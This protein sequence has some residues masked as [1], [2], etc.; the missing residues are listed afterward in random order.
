[1]FPQIPE[2]LTALGLTELKA[3]KVEVA[4]A[5][6]AA[7]AAAD[8]SDEDRATAREL[9]ATVVPAIKQAIADAEVAASLADDTTEPEE[10]EV[11]TEPEAAAAAPVAETT[12]EPVAA[13]TPVVT[14]VGAPTAAAA[15]AGRG[16][17]AGTLIAT[18]AAPGM[19]AGEQF[20]DWLTLGQSLQE[21]AKAIRGNSD[22]KHTV[23]TIRGQFPEARQLGDNPTFNLAKFDDEITAAMCAPLPPVYDLACWNT[24]RRPVYNSLPQFQTPTRGGFSIYPSPTLEDITTGYGQWTSVDDANINAVKEACQTIEC[25]TPEEY[26]IYGVYRCLTV[27]NLLQMTYP[28]LVEAYLNR[29][30]AATARLAE[31]LLLEAMA[32]GCTQINAYQLGYNATTSILSTIINYLLLYQESQRWDV[33]GLMEAWAPRWVV[34]AIQM[35]VVRRKRHDGVVTMVPSQATIEGWFREAGINIHWFIDRPS[36]ATAIPQVATSGLLNFAPRNVE[37]LVAPPGKFALMDRGELS[38]G[39]TGN[40]IYRDNTSNS[41][42]EFTM[43]FE[44]FEGVIDTNTCPA[45]IISIDNLCYNGQQIADLVINC[46]GGDEVGAAS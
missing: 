15:S 40:N 2:N 3:L 45:H 14:T 12:P 36:W 13:A 11:V 6:Q 35:D 18:D 34:K 26:R 27:K 17:S 19:S 30:A 41:R 4:R 23:A 43:F 38:I 42:N 24:T 20:S 39:V 29:L 37:I 31:T 10:E 5:A 44:S 32:N 22:V 16:V 25:A 8:T 7:L 46:E 9:A 28:E 21:R 33:D 1:M